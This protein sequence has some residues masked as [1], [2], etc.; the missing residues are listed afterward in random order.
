LIDPDSIQGFIQRPLRVFGLQTNARLTGQ[1]KQSAVNI[2]TQA[3]R[4]QNAAIN[5]HLAVAQTQSANIA[6]LTKLA[7]ILIEKERT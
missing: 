5:G 4:E 2:D 1:Q 7:T 6:E 3:I